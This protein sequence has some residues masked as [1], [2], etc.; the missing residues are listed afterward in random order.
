MSES[1]FVQT[2]LM[3]LSRIAVYPNMTRVRIML[4]HQ[5][6]SDGVQ[7]ALTSLYQ[8]PSSSPVPSSSSSSSSSSPSD[9]SAIPEFVV[10]I[11]MRQNAPLEM[12]VL[13]LAP[14]HSRWLL[15]MQRSFTYSSSSSSSGPEKHVNLSLPKHLLVAVKRVHQHLG[16]QVFTPFPAPPIA[17]PTE[18]IDKEKAKFLLPPPS[19]TVEYRPKGPFP[20]QYHMALFLLKRVL[21]CGHIEDYKT[22]DFRVLCPNEPLLL[23]QTIQDVNGSGLVQYLGLG[24]TEEQLSAA[25]RRRVVP[26]VGRRVR[27]MVEEVRKNHDIL[28]L[29]FAVG[30][31]LTTQVVATGNSGVPSGAGYC[32]SDVRL[33]SSP[34][35]ILFFISAHPYPLITS[36][37]LVALANEIHWPAPPPQPQSDSLQ[38]VS[39]LS[40]SRAAVEGGGVHVRE[41]ALFEDWVAN[42]CRKERCVLPLS[43]C[44]S[45]CMSDGKLIW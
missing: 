40:H 32:D 2:Q 34:N 14:L 24:D 3:H 10:V 26:C 30:A 33:L 20:G 28:H 1:T 21:D 19:S 31:H 45:V 35:V 25:V 41:D 23:A 38:F 11:A 8:T 9:P 43:V 42:T 4:T 12:T 22:V 39:L 18:L 37:S 44:L 27:E 17:P 6:L 15:E 7:A 5:S 36:H 13:V 29:V 16:T